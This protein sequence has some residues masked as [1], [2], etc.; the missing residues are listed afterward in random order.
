MD[1]CTH[2]VRSTHWR[3]IIQSCQ[4]RPSGQSAK[5]WLDEHDVSEQS[6]YNQ[7]REFFYVSLDEIKDVIRKNYD[8]TVEFVDVP[9]AEQ[10]RETQKLNASAK[11][12][13][14]NGK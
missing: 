13:S 11:F 8:K 2:D 1:Q 5:R 12:C 3:N 14:E 9:D 10:F 6:Y 7:R 4:Q